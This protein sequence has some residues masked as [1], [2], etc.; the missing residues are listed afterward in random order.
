MEKALS[1]EGLKTAV[2]RREGGRG[3]RL[4]ENRAVSAWEH[5]ANMTEGSSS[6]PDCGQ[7]REK[8]VVGLVVER[9]NENQISRPFVQ[10]IVPWYLP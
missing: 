8:E 2:E 4:V 3:T 1:K 9:A 10:S 6:W 7:S 5:K